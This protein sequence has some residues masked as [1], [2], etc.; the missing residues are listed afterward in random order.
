[1]SETLSKPALTYG[2]ARAQGIVAIESDGEII[3]ACRPA[4]TLEAKLEAR[5]ALG[6]PAK[7]LDVTPGEFENHAARVYAHADLSSSAEDAMDAPSDLNALASGLPRTSDLLDSQDDAPVIRLINGILQEAIRSRASD[8]HIEPYEQRLSVRFRIDGTLREM[9]SL[10]ARLASL[11][12]SRVKV[13]AQLDIAK[14]RVPQDG[15][16]SLNLGE[17]AIDVRVSTLPARHG[18]RLV[19]RILEQDQSRLALPELGMDTEVLEPFQSALA[20][21]NGIIL[22]T[23]PTGS[24]KTTTLYAALSQL[25]DGSRNVLTLSLIH[26]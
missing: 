4:A 3:L 9:L 11:L 18:E 24:G 19:M 16:F 5:R 20:R 23:G 17:R 2:F 6:R 8:I 22:V 14:K 25:N 21:P 15:R 26:I 12:V 13:M 1:M 7:L 10:P